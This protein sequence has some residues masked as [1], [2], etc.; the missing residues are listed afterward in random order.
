MEKTILSISLFLH[1]A[2]FPPK[3]LKDQTQTSSNIG[4]YTSYSSCFINR[5]HSLDKLYQY[6]KWHKQI[7]KSYRYLRIAPFGINRC[8]F[9]S[10][11]ICEK[12][13]WVLFEE[14]ERNYLHMSTQTYFKPFV[15][16]KMPNS[17]TPIPKNPQKRTTQQKPTQVRDTELVLLFMILLLET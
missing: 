15:N 1:R 9:L 3:A 11:A 16:N 14:W 10:L 2:Q 5:C 6:I 4:T 13:F 8:S 17:L 7:Q 12:A